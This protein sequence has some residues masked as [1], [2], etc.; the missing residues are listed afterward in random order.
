MFLKKFK[1]ES[2]TKDTL[3]RI[4]KTDSK[5]LEAF[6]QSYSLHVLNKVSD[7]F[8]EINAKQAA[9]EHR[10][11][12]DMKNMPDVDDLVSRIVDEFVPQTDIFKFDGH[13]AT[14]QRSH[15]YEKP[16]VT[17]EE[18]MA[19]PESVRPLCA[20]MLLRKDLDTP[21]YPILLEM[22]E[23][24]DKNADRNAYHLFRQGLDVLDLDPV[25]YRIIGTN[26]NSMGYWL[27]K[28]AD[29]IK[30]QSFLRIPNT[31]VVKVPLCLLQLTRLEYRMLNRTTL[32]IV[33]RYCKEVFELD[34]EKEYFVKTGTY[35]SKYD[36]RNTKVSGES[37]IRELGQYLLFIH[38]QALQMASSLNNRCIY[39]VST[40]NEWVVREYIGDCEN[41]PCIYKGLPLHTEYRVFV[42]FDEK[43]I[44]GINPYWDS[45]IMRKHFGEAASAHDL[46]D[47]VVYMNH[48]KTM[49]QRYNQNKQKV[50]AAIENLLPDVALSGQWS[51]DIMQNGSDFYLIDMARAQESALYDKCVP[52]KLRKPATE[53]WLPTID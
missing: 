31:T 18:L 28:I 25:T 21:S 22:Y 46:H 2:L 47:Y 53:N 8:F 10:E 49:M 16:P 37:E 7:N 42:D 32:N 15:T 4:L 50:L 20:G 23:K 33:N 3:A 40:T 5:K 38:H 30:N 1:K 36:F 27:P 52:S 12:T 19:I 39:G 9:L 29:A 41:N 13:T 17:L 44:I 24:W 51:I 35:S 34:E 11:I 6:E 45:E 26:P 14:I 43:T 48:E